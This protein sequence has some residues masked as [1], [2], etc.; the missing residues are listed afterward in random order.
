MLT[1][2]LNCNWFQK[3]LFFFPSLGQIPLRV[4]KCGNKYFANVV[5]VCVCHMVKKGR[6]KNKNK[7][8]EGKYRSCLRARCRATLQIQS[9]EAAKGSWKF[10]LESA[11]AFY[12]VPV[13][14]VHLVR[15]LLLP[16]FLFACLAVNS[17]FVFYVSLFLSF[18]VH[19]PSITPTE[20]H[21]G[22]STNLSIMATQPGSHFSEE[23]KTCCGRFNF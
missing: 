12:F 1:E 4:L 19:A 3:I 16:L 14:S 5:C 23:R 8:K 6:G 20:R 17:L 7:Q 18:R 15:L 11:A 22:K 13:D 10:I 21:G 2:R 9:C